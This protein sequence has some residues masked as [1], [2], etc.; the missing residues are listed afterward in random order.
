[1]E[2]SIMDMNGRTI[3]HEAAKLGDKKSIEKL[4]H[5]AGPN[6]SQLLKRTDNSGFH[7]VYFATD[8]QVGNSNTPLYCYK[9][10]P[11]RY[12]QSTILVISS[13]N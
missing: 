2:N 5:I 4:L 12:A 8:S 3:L 9:L 1:M 13:P 7:P 6:R 10:G 11:P